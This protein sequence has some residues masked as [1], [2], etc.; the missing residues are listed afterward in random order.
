LIAAQTAVDG[1]ALDQPAFMAL[2]EPAMPAAFRLAVAMLHSDVDAEDAVQ[3]AVYKAWRHRG[4]F[5]KGSPMQ[6]WLLAIVA[7]ECRAARRS[8]WWSVMRLPA[9]SLRVAEDAADPSPESAA[10]RRAIRALPHDHRL[11]V[12]LRYYLD[13][14]FDE[15]AQILNISTKAAKSRTYRALE[16]LR[17][18]PEVAGDEDV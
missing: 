9:G 10:L 8:R 12:A 17:L 14:S 18:D 4:R 6:P 3:E 11:V 13:L 5:R 15:V 1:T 7:N 16:R 2:V